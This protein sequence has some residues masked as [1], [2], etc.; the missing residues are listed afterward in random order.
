V[1]LLPECDNCEHKSAVCKKKSTVKSNCG[2]RYFYQ[3]ISEQLISHYSEEDKAIMKSLQESYTDA[4]NNSSGGERKTGLEF[5]RWLQERIKFKGEK[6]EVQFAFGSFN[7]DYAFPSRSQPKIILEIKVGTDIQH[8]LAIQGLIEN[9][10]PPCSKVGLVTI[11][12]PGRKPGLKQPVESQKNILDRLAEKHKA[13]FGYFHL[14][15]GWSNAISLL[16]QFIA[17][18]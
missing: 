7:V 14:E 4:F 3:M 18:D 6:G 15:N 12:S 13:K 1:L 9:L 5:E 8:C 10:S 17:T 16:N 2:L 11:Y